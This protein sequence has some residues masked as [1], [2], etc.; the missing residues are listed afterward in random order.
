MKMTMVRRMLCVGWLSLLTAVGCASSSSDSSPSD[1]FP[2]GPAEDPGDESV[3]EP[4]AR[5]ATDELEKRRRADPTQ[6][7]GDCPDVE[8]YCS[9]D[10][11][12]CDATGEV[13]PRAL[14]PAGG[15]ADPAPPPDCRPSDWYCNISGDCRCAR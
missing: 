14:C 7:C 13:Y 1:L 8:L 11:C 6:S 12:I 5:G 3:G 9:P 15:A 2:N 10:S 4:A